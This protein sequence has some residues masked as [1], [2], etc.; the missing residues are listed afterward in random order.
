MR[1]AIF[2]PHRSGA[3]FEFLQHTTSAR[4]NI[5]FM[6]FDDTGRHPDRLVVS[7]SVEDSSRVDDLLNALKLSYRMEIMEYDTTGNRLDDTVFYVWFAQK[8]RELLGETGDEF[9]LRLLQ[10]INHIVQEL[11]NLGKDLK[12]TFQNVL[13]TGRTLQQTIGD[14]FYAD[15]QQVRIAPDVVLYCFQ[16]P[17]GGNVFLI[18]TPNEAVMMDTGYG[19]YLQDIGRMLSYYG[20]PDASLLHRIIITHR[21][22]DHAGGAGYFDACA[23]MHP[24]TLDVITRANRAYGSI[25]ETSVLEA[26]Y[27]TLINTFSAFTMPRSVELFPAQVTDHHSIF[28]VLGHI[29]V[30]R[31]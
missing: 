17:G 12:E 13:T 16:L 20:F 3:L 22:A 9:L 29:S 25:A 4:A 14:R 31:Y 27:T 11:M 23:F 6:D 2:L 26:V 19:I 28:P 1:F 30:R 21:D 18:S 15:V 5:A 24:T 7:L 8:L 10:D